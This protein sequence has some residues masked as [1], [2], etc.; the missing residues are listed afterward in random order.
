MA[1]YR[2]IK[3]RYGYYPQVYIGKK[4][5]FGLITI[6]KWLRIGRNIQ[7]F[8]LHIDLDHATTIE[9]CEQRI[10]EYDRTLKEEKVTKPVVVK[11]I[12]IS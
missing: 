11:Y 2:I 5:L 10:Q 6:T 7:G 9:E 1:N 12:T 8:S 3:D 4:Y